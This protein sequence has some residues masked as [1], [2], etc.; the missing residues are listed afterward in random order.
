MGRRVLITYVWIK[1]QDRWRLLSSHQA[2]SSDP[3]LPRNK[4]QFSRIF[5]T[6]GT[7]VIAAIYGLNRETAAG[8]QVFNFVSE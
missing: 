7:L 5:R 2:P 4:D 8:Q 3:E 1:E 6:E